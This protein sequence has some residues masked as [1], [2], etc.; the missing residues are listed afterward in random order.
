MQET[1]QNKPQR[2]IVT[3]KCMFQKNKNVE[4]LL[5]SML[6]WALFAI[7][8]FIIFRFTSFLRDAGYWLFYF[9]IIFPCTFF[10][11]LFLLRTGFKNKIKKYNKIILYFWLS[12]LLNDFLMCDYHS[13]SA[14]ATETVARQRIS[15]IRWT[16]NF[17]C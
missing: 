6:Y 3:Y 8:P 9:F 1:K 2:L 4:F 5:Y 15:E 7:T 10:I 13:P 14:Y 12:F 16:G 17:E 11:F